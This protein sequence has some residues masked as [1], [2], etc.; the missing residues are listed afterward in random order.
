MPKQAT[1]QAV[2][3]ALISEGVSLWPLYAAVEKKV[4]EREG[5]SVETTLTGSSAMQLDQLSKG[6]FDIGFQQSDHVVRAVEGGGDLF[7]FMAVAPAPE[8]T[9]V[10]APDTGAIAG[11]R[12]KVIAVDGARTGYA[13]LLRRVL[14]DAGLSDGDYTLREFGGSAERHDALKQGA[15]SASLLNPPFDRNLLAAGFKSL[16]TSR[17]FFPAYPGPVA[18]ARRSWAQ[19]NKQRL[20]SFIRA[21][22]AGCAW[23]GDSRNKQEA[24]GILPARLGMD[25]QAASRAYDE[26]IKLPPPT[27]TPDGM[28]RVI[29]VVWDAEARTGR[30]GAPDKYMDLSYLDEARQAP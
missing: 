1:A 7:A 29:D 12:G 14:A 28:R 16:G 15:A 20:I 9:L 30:K 5:I 19:Q 17:D 2:R 18:A 11:L 26:F 8:L 25:A 3:L 22:H 13:L 21:F 23:L 4:F 6:A 10:A 24:V 27:I